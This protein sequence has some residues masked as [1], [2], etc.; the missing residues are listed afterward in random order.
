MTLTYAAL[1][2][3]GFIKEPAAIADRLMA[4]YIA[5]N[6]SQS[7]IF[8]D[9]LKSL[10]YTVKSHTDNM[11]AAA[12]KIESDLAELF[13]SYLDNV[14]CNVIAREIIN[15]TNGM[16][17]DKYEVLIDIGFSDGKGIVKLANTI[18]QTNDGFKRIATIA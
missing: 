18:Q 4:D 17:T 11:S 13:S 15:P 5:T 6:F 7:I 9:K 8:F 12:A 1:D 3:V 16:P 2:T 10:Q 14:T